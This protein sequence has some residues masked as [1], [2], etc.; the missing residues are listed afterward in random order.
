MIRFRLV[1]A[2][3]LFTAGSF[4]QSA[5]ITSASL[6][7]DADVQQDLKVFRDPLA[8]RLKSGITAAT[9][10]AMKNEQLR[11]VAQQLLDKKYATQYRLATY[12]A[13][14]SPTTLGEQLMIGDGYS[15]YENITGIFLPAGRHVVLVEMPKGKDVGLLIP[16][17]NRRAPAGI[18]PTE[19]PAG[20]GIIR[21]EF[22]LH[23][24]VN[25]I[26]VKEAGGLAYL[27]YYSDQPKKE[28]AIT[29]H[30]VNGAVNGYFDIAKNTDQDW[31]NLIDHAVYPVI[32]ARGKHIQIVYP[33][34]ACKQYAY[35]R[36]K[37]LISN[38][39]S[40]VYR[41]HRLL[42]LIKYNKVPENHILARVNYNYYMFRDGDGVAYMGTQP[43]NAMPLVVD[44]SRVIKGDPCWGFSHE[45]GH[46]HQV[47]PALN[48]GGLGE[49]SNNIF[50]LYVTTSFGNRSRVSE[51][52]NYQKSK[53]SIIARRICY[54][55]D[56]DVFNRV[57]P[58]WQLQLYFAGPGAY[59]D[60]YPD[61]FEAFRRQ[62][63]AAENGKSGKGGWGDRG[64]NPAVFQLEFVKTVCE[65]SK[66]DLTE[67]FEQYGFFYTG[68]FQ[69]DDYGDY[70][71][72]LTPEMAEACKASIRAMNLP[73]PKVDLTTLSD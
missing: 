45:V 6:P 62:G 20:W 61:L 59:A 12:H 30:F 56:K 4:A 7:V 25:V 9:V 63:A 65:V 38:Y 32:D 14:L 49:V 41:Q 1:G 10:T 28:K 68:E 57:I 27:D 66:T 21:Q 44:P 35:N 53:D 69:Y 34:A 23:A 24:G 60:F 8:T 50:S 3:L 16:N 15:K 19:D 55:Q 36:G 47:R 5:S 37:E 39:D 17:W 26:E 51:Q 18:E 42:G 31:N 71:Y 52:K 13:F 43:G 2:L 72:K 11:R 67:F 70:H 22:K 58:F 54:L 29:V 46:V 48:W 33:A 40:L 64:D 73:K